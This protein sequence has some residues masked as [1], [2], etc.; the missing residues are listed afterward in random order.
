MNKPLH[1]QENEQRYKKWKHLTEG[2]KDNYLRIV[3]ENL[4]ENTEK[5]IKEASTTQNVGTFTTYAFPLIRRIFP[6]LIANQLVSVQPMPMPTAMIFYLDFKYGTDIAPTTAGDRM[7]YQAGKFNPYYGTGARGEIATGTVDGVNTTFSTKYAPIDPNSLVVYVDS[8]QASVASVDGTTGQ[9]T[10]TTAPASGSTVTVDYN[11]AHEG[12]DLAGEIEF[13]ITSDSVTAEQKRLKAKWTLE[14]QQDLYAYHGLNAET[15]LVAML[16]YELKREIDRMIIQDILN[17]TTENINWSSTYDSNSGYSRKEWDETLYHAIV[18]A[19]TAIYKKRL[20]KPNWIVA[21]P[22]VCARLEKISGFRL[23]GG[24]EGG[25]IVKGANLYGTLKNKYRVFSD[26][27]MP[28]N[29]LLIGYKGNSFFET[30][31]VYAPYVPLYTTPTIVDTDFTPRRAI[32]SRFA[33]KLVSNDF[34]ATVTIV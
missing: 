33:R 30:G 4:F 6:N 9:F 3:T 15:E 32:M 1:L 13:E 19:E 16:A 21:S 31:Y 25:T 34:Y 26:P 28:S 23:E 27:E 29:K 8:A 18:D 14:A 20:V 10:L 11:F 5:W 2:I 12:Q 17:N 22:D 24:I 7:D